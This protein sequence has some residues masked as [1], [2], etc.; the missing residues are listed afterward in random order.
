MT[1]TVLL[2]DHPVGKRDDRASRML[3]ARGLACDWLCP[4]KGDAL[5][6]PG[7]QHVAA[8]VYGGT[9]N[10][11]TDSDRPYLQ[12]EME[13]I[14]RWVGEGRRYLGICLGGQLLAA[15]LGAR[16]GPHP[17]GLYEVGFYPVRPAPGAD[18]FLDAALHVYQWHHEGFEVPPGGQL[19]ATGEAFPN[20]AFAVDG[21]AYGL[22]FHPEVCPKVARRWIASATESQGK[23]GFHPPERQIADGE[24]YD[25]AMEAWFT[26]FLDGWLAGL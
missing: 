7:P 22:Q 17:E 19:L 6:A 8:V 1:P 21:T 15:A 13:W 12:A 10:L 18:G 26:R 5:P 24:R 4:G 25:P 20:Q 3:A 14:R 11:S 2:I 9:E 16:V 23:P